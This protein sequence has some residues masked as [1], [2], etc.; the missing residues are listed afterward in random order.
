MKT[1]NWYVFPYPIIV[2]FLYLAAGFLF[3]LWHP[4]WLIFLTIPVYYEMVATLK[5]KNTKNKWYVFPY[6][7]LVFLVY[8]TAGFLFH[9]WHPTWLLFLTIPVYYIMIA[10][11]NAKNF[12]AKANI[13]PYPILCVIFY[14]A[15]GFDYN[16]WH[17]GWLLFLTIPVYY[18]IVNMIKA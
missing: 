2:L 8:L 12:R 13:F 1:F 9:I 6:P 11:S 5:Q 16:L 15:I 3:N 4:T 14:L 18:M 17:P 10:M 7:I